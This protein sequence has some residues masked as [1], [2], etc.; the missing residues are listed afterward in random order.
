MVFNLKSLFQAPGS[1]L[2][3]AQPVPPPEVRQAGGANAFLAQSA[4]F[5][6]PEPPSG[7]KDRTVPTLRQNEALLYEAEHGATPAAISPL[8]FPVGLV[9]A[10]G[11]ARLGYEGFMLPTEQGSP[12]ERYFTDPNSITMAATVE[13]WVD[14]LGR[15]GTSAAGLG[16]RFAGAIVPGKLTLLPEAFPEPVVVPAPLTAALE[17]RI[18]ADPAI[19][20][21][22]GSIIATLRADPDYKNIYRKIDFSLTPYGNWRVFSLLASRLGMSFGIGLSFNLR[23]VT[24]AAVGDHFFDLPLFDEFGETDS[25]VVQRAASGIAAQPR[26]AGWDAWRSWRNEQAPVDRVI[27]LYGG[28][29]IGTPD[30]GQAALA[31]WFAVFFREVHVSFNVRYDHSYAIDVPPFAVVH[32]MS[33]ET[34]ESPPLS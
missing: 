21:A 32:V 4:Q 28:E 8:F 11:T 23:R 6:T 2:A 25:P 14:V 24:R 13:R 15:R 33:E 31:W 30:E 16:A 10:D 22:F 7:R 17:A 26:L 18:D 27:H 9:A 1:D 12:A 29:H 19:G 20:A 5:I 3:E 34:L